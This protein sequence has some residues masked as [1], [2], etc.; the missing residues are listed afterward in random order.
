M[1]RFRH[2]V[3]L[4]L[5]A[6]AQAVAVVVMHKI[7]VTT[8]TGRYVET[9]SITGSKIGF[10]HI[11]PLV[12][13]VLSVVSVASVLA[14]ITLVVL[15]AL[16][17]RRLVLAAAAAALIVGANLTT[18]VLKL[19]F[20]RP[21]MPTMV[22]GGVS[23]SMENTL[24]SGHATVA[25]SVVVAV[26][27]VVPARM[28]GAAAMLAAGYG[29][30]TGVGTL[31]ARWHRPSDVLAACLVVGAWAAVVG[32]VAV[33]L[34]DRRGRRAAPRAWSM[35]VLALFGVLLL[36]L[37]GLALALTSYTDPAQLHR[38]GLFLAYLGG[39]AAIAGACAVLVAGVL[40]IVPWVV[41]DDWAVRWPAGDR[42]SSWP[43]GGSRQRPPRDDP[44]TLAMTQP[45][46]PQPRHRESSDE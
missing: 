11:E 16:L 12:Y 4:A 46:L 13:G 1:E 42:R 38:G 25:L 23:G 10:A 9:A 35:P 19:V 8:L 43:V 31:S 39:S 7:F 40:A 44:P 24:P 27:L 3:A 20:H 36:G 6:V 29:A 17:R 45:T 26:V 18:Q 5:C 28:R 15:V 22:P 30:L 2:L 34:S 37:G 33:V 32:V 14:A 21:E 41:A